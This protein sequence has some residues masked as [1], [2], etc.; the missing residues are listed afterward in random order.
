MVKTS[1]TKVEN[2]RK[3]CKL[4]QDFFENWQAEHEALAEKV[5]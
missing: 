1:D 4:Q 2:L 5:N 3:V